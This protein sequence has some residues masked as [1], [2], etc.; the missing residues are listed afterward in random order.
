MGNAGQVRCE[1]GTQGCWVRQM[2]GFQIRGDQEAK[3]GFATPLVGERQEFDQDAAGLPFETGLQ[4]G[5]EGVTLCVP[6]EEP[7]AVDEVERC[8]RLAAQ[9]MN[10]AALVHDLIVTT[11]K[12]GSPAG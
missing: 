9:G 6:R 8:H 2:Q 5:V 11:V 3:L 7:I 1:G 12:M 10:D 4:Q